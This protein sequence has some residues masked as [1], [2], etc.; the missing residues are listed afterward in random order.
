MSIAPNL[1]KNLGRTDARTVVDISSVM[2]ANRLRGLPLVV[3][4]LLSLVLVMDGFD[5]VVAG[6]AAP[7]ISAQFGLSRTDM[8]WILSAANGGVALGAI[9]GGIVGDRIGRRSLLLAGVA[10]YSVGTALCGLAPS[11]WV[12]MALRVAASIGLGAVTAN[13]AAFLI[14]VLPL[15]WRSQLT[16]FAYAMITIGAVFCG[17]A[18]K[19]LLP[20]FG[21]SVLFLVGGVGPLVVLLPL[22]VILLPETPGFLVGAGRSS[23][24]IAKTLNRLCSTQFTGGEL[25]TSPGPAAQ[26]GRFV[27]LFSSTYLRNT[28][29][30]WA[31]GASVMFVSV[32]NT[33]MG[34]LILTA[35]GK[36][37]GEAVNVMLAFNMFAV[38]GG[39]LS[40]LAIRQ[41]GSRVTLIL[42]TLTA[43]VALGGLAITAP[44]GGGAWL[45]ICFDAIGFAIG[46]LAVVN[47]PLAANVYPTAIRSTGTGASA[48]IGRV[49]AVVS[50]AAIGIVLT[51]A[52]AATVFGCLAGLMVI[53]LVAALVL[54]QHLARTPRI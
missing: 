36:S 34:T 27:Q 24:Q 38:G 31:L 16:T 50:A 2:D 47:F 53:G 19:F 8:G 45:P 14:E 41:F 39:V 18:A 28:L 37:T 21:W 10:L 17:T 48:S 40:V 4:F 25:F 35:M 54:R 43:A 12:F 30:L 9:M 32:A 52:G 49:A 7:S 6:F 29:A 33:N 13:V 15:R 20:N 46:G 51:A 42:L 22:L 1:D 5:L 26:R 23:E 44:V 11:A 3:T